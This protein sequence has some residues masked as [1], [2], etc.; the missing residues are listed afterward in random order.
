MATQMESL[1]QRSGHVR[2]SLL[3]L[4]PMSLP[5]WLLRRIACEVR[6]GG[7]TRSCSSMILHSLPFTIERIVRRSGEFLGLVTGPSSR[8]DLP[9]AAEKH[10]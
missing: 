9:R 5:P 1:R 8:P 6:Q 3:S 4:Q 2:I 10:G 7:H